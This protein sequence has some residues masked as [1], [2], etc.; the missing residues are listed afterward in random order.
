[1]GLV[2]GLCC[3]EECRIIAAETAQTRFCEAILKINII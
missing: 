1:M 3:G 2:I